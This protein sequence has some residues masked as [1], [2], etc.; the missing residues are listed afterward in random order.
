M[1]DHFYD[2][3]IF[4]MNA[5]KRVE[6]AQRSIQI[7]GLIELIIAFTV[8]AWTAKSQNSPLMR[9]DLIVKAIGWI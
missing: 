7:L 1:N 6:I 5:Y 4:K 8:R 9:R 2:K 3:N